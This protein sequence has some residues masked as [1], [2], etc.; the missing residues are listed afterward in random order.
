[1]QSV[2]Q[3]EINRPLVSIIT[4]VF[5]SE[6]LIENTILSIIGQSYKNIEYIIVDGGSTD[7]TLEII[8][9]YTSHISKWI[10]EK[11]KGLYDAMNKGLGMASGEYVWFINSGD[12]I[13]STDTLEKIFNK[14]AFSPDII[15]GETQIIDNEGNVLGMRRHAAPENLD[16]KM[17]SKGMLVCHQSV[18]VKKEKAGHYQLNY[19]HSSDYDWLIRVL[20][21]STQIV[22]SGLILSQFLEGGQTSKN[23]LPGLKERFRIMC[24]NYG[25]LTTIINHFILAGRLLF[26]YLKNRRI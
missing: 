22:N 13:K 5:N 14:T 24:R 11:D 17:L 8:K 26:Y 19:K 3:L 7:H 21:N 18:I 4:V 20:K 9:K 23:L 2:Q 6:K 10:S 15:Y 25:T 16:W 12:K 1:M